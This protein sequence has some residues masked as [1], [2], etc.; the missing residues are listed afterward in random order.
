MLLGGY[1]LSSTGPVVLGAARD[2]TGDFGASM[3]ILVGIAVA[4]VA[5]CLTLSPDRLRRGIHR[6]IAT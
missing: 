1:V 5:S 4:L 3:W 6:E 2:V